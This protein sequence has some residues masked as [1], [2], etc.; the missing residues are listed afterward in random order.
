[1]KIDFEYT[2]NYG[3]YRD[4]LHIADD[5]SFTDDEI[6]AMKQSR[7]NNWI[8]NIENPIQ[9]TQEV[10]YIEVDGVRYQRVE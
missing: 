3:V 8:F 10:N 4:A 6:E 1:M 7:L 2:T 9:D 5:H